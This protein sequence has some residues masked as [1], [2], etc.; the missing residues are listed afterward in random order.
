MSTDDEKVIS[1]DTLLFKLMM[2]NYDE[3]VR[4]NE[5]I[6]SK[7]SQMI[8]FLGIMFTIQLTLFINVLSEYLSNN[9][10]PVGL[11]IFS[12][13]LLIFS[14]LFYVLS[15][16]AFIDAYMFCGDF[17]S[18]PKCDVLLQKS[19]DNVSE[20]KLLK[21]FLTNLPPV[22]KHN[23]DLMD[24]KVKKASEG[25]IFL[26]LGGVISIFFIIVILASMIYY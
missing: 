24:N 18:F 3:E 5:L 4:R 9:T 13:L 21:S 26:K 17:K 25:F 7:N 14:L 20:R 6:D 2:H 12:C 8:A 22:M 1:Q 15:I 23:Y 19:K 11:K 16:S 10:W